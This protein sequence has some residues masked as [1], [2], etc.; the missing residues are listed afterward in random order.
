MTCQ[1]RC[2]HFQ[3]RGECDCPR[4]PSVQ[5]SPTAGMTIAQRILHVGGRNNA[6]GYVEFGST[7]AVE[8]LVQQV[9]RDQ[10]AKA[11]VPVEP[12]WKHI[13]NEWADEACNAVV[14]LQNVRDGLTPANE[15]I[16]YMRKRIERCRALQAAP[17]ADA[18]AVP[19]SPPQA[20]PLS[21]EELDLMAE[22]ALFCRISL[23]QFARSIEAYHGIGA[24]PAAP[25]A[26]DT[27]PT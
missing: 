1:D 21:D 11:S 17:T 8:A 15:G 7:Q 25:S 16:A 14:V 10:E 13:A 23:Q 3:A 24:A 27:E 12:N 18:A 20:L 4:A 22:K 5:P 6:A 26:P 19:A 9:L 2:P